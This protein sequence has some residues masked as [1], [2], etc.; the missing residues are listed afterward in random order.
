MKLRFAE[1]QPAIPGLAFGFDSRGH[2]R[3][4]EGGGYEKASLGFYVVG[5]KTLPFSEYWQAHAGVARTLEL[6]KAKPDFFAGVSARFSQEFSILAEY[7]VGTD[8]TD[9]DSGSKT[10]F[11]NA[12]LRWVFMDQLQLDFM[13]RNL[14]GPRDSPGLASRSIAF[15]FYDIF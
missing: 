14:V 9:D 5:T 12:G 11:L 8:R 4:L 1:E 2:G 10:G 6:P 7:H 3:E 13:F 15:T